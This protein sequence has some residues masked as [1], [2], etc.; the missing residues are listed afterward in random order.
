MLRGMRNGVKNVEPRRHLSAGSDYL[1]STKIPTFH[2]QDSLPRLP[3]P[4][5][6][7]TAKV[8][9]HLKPASPSLRWTRAAC[10]CVCSLAV[11]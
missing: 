8:A 10:A 2:F 3:I 4:E 1:Q 7:K 9:P 5:L 11:C 6:E